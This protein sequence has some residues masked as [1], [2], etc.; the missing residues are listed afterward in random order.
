MAATLVEVVG[1]TVVDRKVGN[2]KDGVGRQG[3]RWRW[4]WTMAVAAVGSGG[5]V[6]VWKSGETVEGNGGPARIYNPV[7]RP[8]QTPV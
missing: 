8:P 5:D 1:L 4:R 3:G 6:K 2:D 7:D